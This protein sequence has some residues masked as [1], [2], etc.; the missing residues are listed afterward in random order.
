MGSSTEAEYAAFLEKVRRTV[1]LDNLS[2]KVTES[3][4]KTALN[5][6]GSVKNVQFI[7]NYLESKNIQRFALVEMDDSNQAK[8]VLSSMGEFP[9]MMSGMP[10]PVRARAAEVEMFDD[11]PIKPGRTIQCR[12]L[13]PDDPDFQVAQKLKRVVRK[14]AAEASFVLKQQVDQEEKLAKQQADALKQNYKKYELLDG[15]LADGTAN[16]LAWYYGMRNLDD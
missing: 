14:H 8:A 4:L 11:R 1:Y 12:W 9:F 7:P 5:Q 15:I 6:F 3:V 10:R 2:P 13:E 16:R